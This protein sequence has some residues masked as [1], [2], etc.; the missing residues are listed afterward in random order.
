MWECKQCCE[1]LEDTFDLCWNCGTPKLG[2]VET[3]LQTSVESEGDA[4]ASSPSN[5]QLQS[6][7]DSSSP[8]NDV[9]FNDEN[10]IVSLASSVLSGRNPLAQSHH[11]LAQSLVWILRGLAVLAVIWGAINTLNAIEAWRIA[12]NVA[13]RFGGFPNGY[14]SVER[15]SAV[16]V[17]SAF[18]VSAA[19]VTVLLAIG[20]M[21]KLT[22]TIETGTRQM[23]QL[24]EQHD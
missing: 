14:E 20:E 6:I 2:D 17:F 23:E 4:E 22:V 8:K 1:K 10:L 16:G 24:R 13:S 11:P 18:L 3:S 9:R 21:L 19:M 7:S 15:A 12:S 5:A